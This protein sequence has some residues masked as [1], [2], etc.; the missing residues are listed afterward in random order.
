MRRQQGVNNN[1]IT[2][3]KLYLHAAVVTGNDKGLKAVHCLP[4][5]HHVV[6][7]QLLATLSNLRPMIKGV[8]KKLRSCDITCCST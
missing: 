5:P 2:H 1:H 3:I 6:A 7:A 8:M 4:D